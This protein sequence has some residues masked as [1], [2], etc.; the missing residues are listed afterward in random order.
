MST[1]IYNGFKFKDGI[2]LMKVHKLIMSFRVE[3]K[4]IVFE[5]IAKW[6]AKRVSYL[7]DKHCLFEKVKKD[8][9]FVFD[10]Y[11]ELKDR[12]IKIKKT[13]QRDP[14]I[15]FTFN[16]SILPMN[17]KILGIY[18]GE[19]KR[20]ID[21][22]NSKSYV[23]EYHYQNQTDR[24]NLISTKEWK[25]RRRDWYKVLPGYGIPSECGFSAD[26]SNFNYP[27]VDVNSYIKFLPCLEKRANSLIDDILFK[28]REEI[29]RKQIIKEEGKKIDD[30]KQYYLRMFFNFQDWK[31]TNEGK[32]IVKLK[33]KEIKRKLKRKISKN[34]LL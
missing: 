2:D 3:V 1:K 14:E 34:D 10:V 30:F 29:L 23:V 6:S 13:N 11:Q 12:K 26:I 4:D 33:I 20:I 15:D 7:Y 19:N 8:N 24:P 9:N 5:E 18:Y 22:W 31:K 17:N 32:N 28:E 25:Q 21:A 27:L 16:I